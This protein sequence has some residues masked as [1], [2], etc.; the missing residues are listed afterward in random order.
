MNVSPDITMKR[1]AEVA[2]CAVHGALNALRAAREAARE[3]LAIAHE[4]SID[5]ADAEAI[6]QAAQRHLDRVEA[7]ILALE[8]AAAT[9]DEVCAT[10]ERAAISRLGVPIL[11]P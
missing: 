10:V 11:P 6:R 7:A 2:Q 9:A 1:R 4:L 8:A 3:S 5:K